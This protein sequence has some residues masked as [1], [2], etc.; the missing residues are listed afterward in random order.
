MLTITRTNDICIIR[1]FA[2]KFRYHSRVYN[3][4]ALF[5]IDGELYP[6]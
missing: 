5:L 1:G 3:H 2:R 4:Q 6:E